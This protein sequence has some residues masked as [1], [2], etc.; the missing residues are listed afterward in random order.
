MNVEIKSVE[1]INRMPTAVRVHEGLRDWFIHRPDREE[2]DKVKINF[3]AQKESL[4]LKGTYTMSN[5]DY[6]KNIND[7]EE[8]VKAAI[9]DKGE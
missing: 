3:S 7:L 4:K 1:F 2:K 6:V 5:E 9:L 8:V